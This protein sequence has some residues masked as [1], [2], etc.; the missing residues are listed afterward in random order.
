MGNRKFLRILLER[1]NRFSPSHFVRPPGNEYVDMMS[2]VMR[3]QWCKNQVDRI[4]GCRDIA[5]TRYRRERRRVVRFMFFF[6]FADAVTGIL[7]LY[8]IV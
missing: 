1:E 5:K 4:A 8:L 6:F 3:F 2:S 7:D